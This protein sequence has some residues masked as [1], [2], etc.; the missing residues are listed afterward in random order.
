MAIVRLTSE[1]VTASSVNVLGLDGGVADFETPE[2]IAAALRRAA[3]FTCPASPRH[4]I[5]VVEESW[6]G[7]A[8]ADSSDSTSGSQVEA[9]LDS[10]VAHGDLIEAPILDE[11]R[12]T[13]YRTLFLAPPAYV[14]VSETSCL[15]LGIRAEGLDLLDNVLADRMHHEIHVRRLFIGREEDPALMLSSFGLREITS[16]QWLKHPPICAPEMLVSEYNAR[17]GS[18]GPSGGIEG[19]R[20]LDPAKRVTYYRGRWREPGKKDTG[21]YVARRPVEFGPDVWCYAE[22]QAG[23]V[24]RVVDLAWRHS[25]DR[26]CDEAWRLQAALDRLSGN[27]QR[28]RVEHPRGI[29]DPLLH[30]YSPIPSWAQRRLNALGRALPKRRGSL[31]SYSVSEDQL[32]NEVAFLA[33]TMWIARFEQGEER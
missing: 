14:R 15:L 31:M 30:L 21:R 5:Q 29:N 10:L 19:C 12:R 28:V 3:S 18:A 4:L 17:L 11:D 27:A 23:T 32:A 1:E 7:L 24:Q 2:A 33:E 13:S 9:I 6:R 25:L 20:I 26:A 22:F 8:A 16:E